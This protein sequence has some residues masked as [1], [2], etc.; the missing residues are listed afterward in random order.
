MYRCTNTR[1]YESD[2]EGRA[3]VCLVTFT[4]SVDRALS[5]SIYVTLYTDHSTLSI[6][7]NTDFYQLLRRAPI[8]REL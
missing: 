4:C 5:A 3:L 8:T 2:E 7:R 1:H 6:R